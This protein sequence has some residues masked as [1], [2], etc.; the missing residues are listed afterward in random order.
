MEI[1]FSVGFLSKNL[2]T[3]RTINHPREENVNKGKFPLHLN[4]N[5]ELDGVLFQIKMVH[6][7]I[8]L[9]PTMRLDVASIINEPL[10]FFREKLSYG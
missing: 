10:P 4:F 5:R 8:Q 9:L 3:D 6:K 1:L 2:V 7:Q